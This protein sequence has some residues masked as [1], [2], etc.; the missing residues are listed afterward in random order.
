MD[1]EIAKKYIKSLIKLSP[2]DAE[3]LRQAKRD[4]SKKYNTTIIANSL[5]LEYFNK[6][7]KIKGSSKLLRILRKREIRT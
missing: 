6:F 4:L 3:G 2:S 1:K 7:I 5:I